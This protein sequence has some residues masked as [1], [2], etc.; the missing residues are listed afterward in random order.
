ME[1]LTVVEIL[2]LKLEATVLEIWKTRFLTKAYFTYTYNFSVKTSKESLAN[3]TSWWSMK[4]KHE[5]QK[6][7]SAET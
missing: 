4:L 7:N 1:E 6:I 5:V 3:S 2:K